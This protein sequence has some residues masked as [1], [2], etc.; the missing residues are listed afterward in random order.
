[1]KITFFSIL[2]SVFLFLPANVWAGTCICFDTGDDCREA[3]DII[4]SE[5]ECIEACREDVFGDNYVDKKF[6]ENDPSAEADLLSECFARHEAIT[7]EEVAPSTMSMMSPSSLTTAAPNYAGNPLCWS[8]K[9]CERDFTGDGKNDGTFDNASAL[10]KQKCGGEYG[11]CYP[12][13]EDFTLSVA[14]PNEKEYTKTVS[15]LG[16]YL[17]KMYIFMLGAAAVFVVVRIMAAGV[18]YIIAPAG[19]EAKKAQE[20]ITGALAGLVILSCAALILATVNPQLL[21]L[22]PPRTPKIRTSIYFGDGAKC[23]TYSRQGYVFTPETDFSSEDD[24]NTCGAKGIIIKDVNQVDLVKPIECTWT[25]CRGYPVIYEEGNVPAFKIEKTC[26]SGVDGEATCRSCEEIVTGPNNDGSF[27]SGF[28]PDQEICNTLQPKFY[29]DADA[30]LARYGTYNAACVFNQDIG[31]ESTE[32]FDTKTNGQ[33]AVVAFDCGKINKCT[34]YDSIKVWNN[35]G[36][37]YLDAFDAPGWVFDSSYHKK[38]CENNICHVPG[39][40]RQ[41]R[42]EAYE[43]AVD[44]G[45]ALLIPAPGGLGLVA[46]IGANIAVWNA[47]TGTSINGLSCEPATTPDSSE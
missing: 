42:T 20:K 33:C 8:L 36:F 6:K 14:L 28:K 17:N 31:F 46:M 12:I 18:Q 10:A 24:V 16:D 32:W 13:P 25:G 19:G 7:G 2:F 47:V 3:E 23:E 43:I 38:L 40:C 22:K 5:E 21:T 4:N 34:D 37:Q 39:G 1:M 26:Y 30:L 27:D 41:D 15:D 11:F 9:S 45:L 29:D 44:T 35:D